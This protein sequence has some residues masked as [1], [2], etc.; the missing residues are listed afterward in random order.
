MIMSRAQVVGAL[1]ITTGMEIIEPV[2]PRITIYD[3][4]KFIL[5]P[6]L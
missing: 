4:G 5:T 2:L 6:V 1:K 3:A